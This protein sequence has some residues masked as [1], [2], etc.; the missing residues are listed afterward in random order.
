MSSRVQ[1]ERAGRHISTKVAS[2]LLSLLMLGVWGIAGS[3]Q[4]A[5]AAVPPAPPTGLTPDGTSAQGNPLLSW[6][7]TPGATSYRV[8]VKTSP[9][10]VVVNGANNQVVYSNHFAF[11][12]ELALGDYTWS[13]SAVG[14][15][16][17]STS[18]GAT[19]NKAAMSGPS[20]LTP[21]D[22]AT[23]TYPTAN[24][25]FSWTPVTGVKTYTLE[26]ST[27]QA[28]SPATTVTSTTQAT[29][30]TPSATQ[31]FG[32]TY[33]WRVTGTFTNTSVNTGVSQVR[34]YQV[35][36]G[37]G[38]LT[39]PQLLSPSNSATNSVHD[40]VLKW[41]P[42]AGAATYQVQVSPNQD[43]T[44]NLKVDVVTDSTL[45]A[46]A[47]SLD[48]GTYFWRVRA[49]TGGGGQGV[50]SPV[51]QFSRVPMQQVTLLSPANS[52]PGD[53]PTQAADLFLSWNP[54]PEASAYELVLS[55]DPNFSQVTTSQVCIT[56]HTDWGP[57][58]NE[59]GVGATAVAGPG[60]PGACP[61]NRR[62]LS[63][64]F[65]NNSDNVT[66][67][68]RVRGLD[69]FAM[70]ELPD[71][72]SSGATPIN[73][74]WSEAWHFQYHADLGAPTLQSPAPGSNVTVP[75][76]KW[77]TVPGTSYY[78][79][80]LAEQ[81]YKWDDGLSACV[82]DGNVRNSTYK[83]SA[84]SFVPSL[85]KP[86]ELPPTLKTCGSHFDWTVSAVNGGNHEGPLPQARGFNLTSL[87]SRTNTTTITPVAVQDP[88]LPG[89]VAFT[90]NGIQGTDHYEVRW[91][92][93]GGNSYTVLA[94]PN[95]GASD[96]PY[97]P[98]TAAYTTTQ[99]QNP[100][101]AA[102]QIVALDAGNNPL[103]SSAKLPITV[104]WPAA[105]QTGPTNCVPSNAACQ[106]EMSTPLLTWTPVSGADFYRVIIASDPNFT[107][108]ARQY[109]T[110]QT[111]FRSVEALPDNQAGQ[112]YYWF[113]QPCRYDWKN[114]NS[115]TC[116]ANETSVGASHWAF[117]KRSAPVAGVK[118]L[119]ASSPT[120]SPDSA[121]GA[122]GTATVS[123]SPTLCW[124]SY[125]GVLN[126]DVAAMSYHIQVATDNT[127]ASNVLVDDYQV[128]QASYTP[129]NAGSTPTSIR[130]LTY[131]E[132][133]LYWRVQPRD[134]TG[135]YLTW[136]PI[137]AIVKS[138][139]P[140]TLS[141]PANGAPVSG[142]PSLVWNSQLFAAK[143][144]VQIYKNG[145]TNWSSTN[146]I[147]SQVTDLT[148]HAATQGGNAFQSLPQGQYAWRVQAIDAAGRAGAWSTG[149]TFT[150]DPGAPTLL[151]PASGESISTPTT[152][153]S[154]TPVIGAVNYR[155]QESVN[156]NLTSPYENTISYSTSWAPLANVPG[157]TIYWNVQALDGQG[158]VLGTS[159]T[160]TFNYTSSRPTA[161][162]PT[163]VTG[164]A[165]VRLSWTASRVALIG[166]ITMYQIRGYIGSGTTAVIDQ[167]VSA[168][169]VGPE[170]GASYL[171][172]G[173]VN[174]TGYT[175]T[176][177]PFD[178]NDIGI[179]SAR[180]ATLTP[181]Q[182]APFTSSTNCVKRLYSDLAG[183]TN[184]TPAQIALFTG[185]I[186]GGHSCADVALQFWNQ[187]AFQD[188]FGIS[189][190][191]QAYFL[192]IPDYG[193]INYWTGL[194]RTNGLSLSSMSSYFAQSAEFIGTYGQLSNAQFMSLIY[195]NVLHRTP[196]PGG[197]NYWLG[198]L[199]AGDIGRGD[200][201]LLFSES[202]E[203]TTTQMPTMKADLLIL[204]F[205]RRTPTQAEVNYYA[206]LMPYR[207]ESAGQRSQ[208]DAELLVQ[209]KAIMAT[210]EYKSRA[211]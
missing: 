43:W 106:P 92:A 191:Y 15:G 158:G 27:D 127:F 200:V 9:A 156:S 179:E 118:T 77:S 163:G 140:V 105:Q 35:L 197:Y 75:L 130:H 128:D 49:T 175:F 129:Y 184:P 16:G 194:H 89:Q 190:I 135:N 126:N 65:P 174:N 13:V 102:Y 23:I 164:D 36:W 95:R 138:T 166:P 97:S 181:Q 186:T 131:P 94:D 6:A 133:S 116:G 205:L 201:M 187:G 154:W 161:S 165:S 115:F 172:S 47:K 12:N 68:W 109:I 134:A 180:S 111:K 137:Q 26:I 82:S 81:A 119:Q 208:M 141:S 202:P 91:F 183:V 113:V 153:F 146:L 189:R 4:S 182:W 145:D 117:Q 69:Y 72:W 84:T 112:A 24:P 62:D 73:G 58:R 159:A 193:G 17:T 64:L 51:W 124:S 74:P 136:S 7:P 162:Q 10:G 211:N 150:V 171:V 11:Q 56:N 42:V 144:T 206:P 34:S 80:R 83:T 44:N 60:G 88:Q 207:G 66:I 177:T 22:G 196:D 52:N 160:G 121:C 142:S 139:P 70:N 178:A 90:W 55:A 57:Y 1:H 125:G 28:F 50:W 195:S 122:G 38:G 63:G 169:T 209:I 210:T 198:K 8:L 53:Y 32:Q 48:N 98:Y 143:Y 18:T 19:F 123:G 192:R 185:Y 87:E 14:Q 101:S 155:V 100:G 30:Y 29:S 103:A 86:I 147:R 176:I 46:P 99:L 76:L 59:A 170:S 54:V 104:V 110:P 39:A 152:L 71:P 61:L 31:A 149:S 79:V 120:P 25:T 37:S 67:Y 108:K 21:A 3:P 96:P 168:L 114:T 151:S 199:N 148:S 40:V 93:G 20:L 203:Y 167:N 132:G 2:I 78:I 173:L 204:E 45:Y 157:G 85:K 188:L 5:N 107:N 33:Y 41:T